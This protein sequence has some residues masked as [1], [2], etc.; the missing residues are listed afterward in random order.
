MLLHQSLPGGIRLR[1]PH[2][3]DVASAHD[4]CA[5]HGETCDVEAML[6]FDP[7]RQAV[8]VAV[9]LGAEGEDVVGLGT[10][11]L[12]AGAEPDLLVADDDDVRRHLRDALLARVIGRT[13][14]PPRRSRGVRVLRAVTRRR[15]A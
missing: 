14:R 15:A 2:R 3:T 7:R 4:L 9:A 10:I 13:R 6:R 11:T 1:L 8:V 12:R 5:R